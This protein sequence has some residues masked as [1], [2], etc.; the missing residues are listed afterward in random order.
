[1]CT[2]C[3]VVQAETIH[4]AQQKNTAMVREALIGTK[5]VQGEEEHSGNSRA[6][7]FLLSWR[8]RGGLECACWCMDVWSC[9]IICAHCRVT[10]RFFL[11]Y[12]D[13]RQH[14]R[15]TGSKCVAFMVALTTT[16]KENSSQRNYATCVTRCGELAAVYSSGLIVFLCRRSSGIHG[17]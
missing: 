10:W 1:M 5:V 6:H 8:V 15:S 7:V 16:E 11:F 3:D 13:A 12:F 4:R 14:I 17:Y 9:Q 2:A